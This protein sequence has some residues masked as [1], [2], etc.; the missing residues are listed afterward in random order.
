M[1]IE[2]NRDIDN[3]KETVLLG[4]T[5]RQLIYSVLSLI[6]GGAV[7][8]LVYPYAGLTVSAYV[9]IPVA[10][11][12]A[13][14]GFYSYNGMT[15]MQLMKKKIGFAFGSKALSYISTEGMNEIEGIRHE[16]MTAGKKKKKG[17]KN[18]GNTIKRV[19]GDKKGRRAII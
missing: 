13:L 11:P 4:L 15:F 8:L 9:A 5:A 18:N 17:R 12:V 2:F 19:Q 6:A 3:Y 7:V 14:S 16:E 1:N 10:A